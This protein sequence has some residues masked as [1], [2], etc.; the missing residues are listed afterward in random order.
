LLADLQ[1]RVY[2]NL[3][4][5]AL[6]REG[7]SAGGEAIL[8]IGGNQGDD[9]DVAHGG[10][11]AAHLGCSADVFG[12]IRG[13]KTEIGVQSVPQIISIEHEGVQAPREKLSRSTTRERVDFPDPGR[14]VSHTIQPL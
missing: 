14:P 12:P 1:G 5:V 8:A 2:K 11:Q 9:R 4:K 3:D 7:D 6:P 13:R 10:S